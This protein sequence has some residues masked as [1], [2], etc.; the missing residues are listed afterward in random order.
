MDVLIIIG[1]HS[2]VDHAP[3]VEFPTTCVT[4]IDVEFRPLLPSNYF[5]IQQAV[6][7]D[8]YKRQT[9]SATYFPAPYPSPSPTRESA[10]GFSGR[11]PFSIFQFKPEEVDDM[12][13]K[14]IVEGSGLVR[15]K[16][17]KLRIPRMFGSKR[18]KD[19]LN[20]TL[21]ALCTTKLTDL[22]SCSK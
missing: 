7:K 13:R 1:N 17:I 22:W 21:H 14:R 8:I 11:G 19:R 12:N 16:S 20:P 15:A 18:A 2:V 4:R 10:I 6:A 5:A 3:V 9:V